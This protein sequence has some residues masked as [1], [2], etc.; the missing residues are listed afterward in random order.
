MIVKAH[1]E[2][3]AKE[4]FRTLIYFNSSRF[5]KEKT[6]REILKQNP[7]IESAFKFVRDHAKLS[8]TASLIYKKLRWVALT[9][10]FYTENNI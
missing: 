10:V 5:S 4:S 8:S 2:G 9:S 7:I 1:I 3:I 6:A